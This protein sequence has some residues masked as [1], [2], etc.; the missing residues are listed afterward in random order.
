MLRNL[1]NRF[2]VAMELRGLV[3]RSLP[4][5][6]AL[7]LPACEAAIESECVAIQIVEAELARP[8][9]SIVH[10]VRSALYATLPVGAEKRVGVLDQKPQADCGHF[11]IE[12][13]LHVDLDCVT[14][15]S[16]I[17]RRIDFVSKGEFEAKPLD[18]EF[19]RLLD[20]SGAENRMGFFERYC[21]AR[22]P[23]T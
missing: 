1:L 5:I 10:A 2:V 6:R 15:K 19:N 7:L 16:D 8:P 20:V 9:R 21:L 3:A 22:I 23:T 13:K 12:L 14:T 17:V 4:E 11:V 18:V